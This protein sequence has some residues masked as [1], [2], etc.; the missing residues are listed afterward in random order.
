MK[1]KFLFLSSTVFVFSFTALFYLSSCKKEST[2]KEIKINKAFPELAGGAGGCSKPV[3]A[4]ESFCFD[5]MGHPICTPGAQFCADLS[6]CFDFP[7]PV[8]LLVDCGNPWNYLK[9]F[10]K[11]IPDLSKLLKADPSP[12]PSLGYIP[13]AVTNKIAWLQFYAPIDKVL[14]KE[15]LTLNKS[16]NLDKNNALK[17]GLIGNTI[18]AGKYPVVYDINTKTY[19]A[20]VAVK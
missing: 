10:N 16:V 17:Q 14:T 11:P 13:I 19:N 7:L 1:K 6:V 20:I 8:C 12:Q 4:F 2:N 5:F 15:G 3:C 18:P 9:I